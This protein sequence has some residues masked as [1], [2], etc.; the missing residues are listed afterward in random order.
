MDKIIGN[1]LIEL[2]EMI[3]E[4]IDDDENNISANTIKWWDFKNKIKEIINNGNT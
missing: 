2:V 1:I 3:W 4:V